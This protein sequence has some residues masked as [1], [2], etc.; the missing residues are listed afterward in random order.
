MTQID[1]TPLLPVLPDVNDGEWHGHNQGVM[2]VHPESKVKVLYSN[3]DSD[4][5]LARQI[6]WLG[7]SGAFRVVKQHKEVEA[8]P[9]GERWIIG[10]MALSEAGAKDYADRFGGDIIHMR[11]V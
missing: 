5:C 2:P 9:A 4:T 7:Y 10:T 11:E 1:R 3:R 6:S 8:A